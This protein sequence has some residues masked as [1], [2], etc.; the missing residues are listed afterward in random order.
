MLR[1]VHR[2]C[3]ASTFTKVIIEYHVLLLKILPPEGD[4]EKVMEIEIERGLQASRVMLVHSAQQ[5][6]V[7]EE[8][9]VVMMAMTAKNQKI[10]TRKMTQKMKR[11]ERKLQAQEPVDSKIHYCGTSSLHQLAC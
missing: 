8:E 6:E 9:E 4:R 1:S 11:K 7:R 10:Q 2:F 3:A 5:E